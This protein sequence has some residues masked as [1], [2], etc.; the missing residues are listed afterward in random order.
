MP[1]AEPPFW[2]IY[3][4][5]PRELKALEE[6]IYNRLEKG[7]IRESISPAG[8]A[9]IFAPKKD[10]TLRL[11]V[12]YQGLN[13]LTIKNCY[14]ILLIS[15]LLDQLY[16]AKVFSKIDLLDTYYQIQIKEGD[17]WKTAF[18]TCYGYYEFL[19]IPMGLT[20]TLVT[21]QS[22]INNTLWGYVNDFCIVY[23]D[24]ILIYLRSKEEH[25]QHLEKIIECLCQSELYANPKKCS[26]FQDEIKFLGYLVNTNGVQMDPKW[27]EAIQE[28][29]NHPPRT[30]WD[31]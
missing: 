20:N 17:E 3:N 14:P 28:W 7:H 8:A 2:P 27:I 4:L 5:S 13:A 30:F 22:Y 19:V 24:D 1:G 16:G 12:D 18:Q 11:C 9:V 21:F 6:F 15:E 23:L 25:I 10:G 31:I 26:F 29:K